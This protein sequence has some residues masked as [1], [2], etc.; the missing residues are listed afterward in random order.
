MNQHTFSP[1][2]QKHT[3]G[4][5]RITGV[6]FLIGSLW[7]LFSDRFAAALTQDPVLLTQISL[8]KGWGY[9]F[10][11]A[12][13]LYGMIQRFIRGVQAGERDLQASEMRFATIFHA[14]PIGIC[15]S[16]IETGVLVEVNE[17][18]LNLFGYTLDEVVGHS[19]IELNLWGEPA[20]RKWLIQT[21]R[22]GKKI[23]NHELLSRKKSGELKPVLVSSEIVVFNGQEYLLSLIADIFER[24][25]AEDE[26]QAQRDFALQVMN[27]MGQGLTVTDRGRKFEFANLAFAHMV[28][29]PL[30]EI[31]KH[32]TVDFVTLEDMEIQ[33]QAHQERFQGKTTSY[34]IHLKQMNGPPRPVLITGVPRM[35]KG[36][37]VGAISVIT[38][39]TERK[40]AE[41][42][43]QKSAA[44]LTSIFRAAPIG[45]GK[46]TNR[47]FEQVNDRFCQITGYAREEL[48]GQSARMIYASTEEYE[49]VGKEKF[50]QMAETGV[51]VVE[52]H[53]QRKDG[54]RIEIL[55]SSAY[56]DATHPE[57]GVTFTAQ[58]I[59]AR[60]QTEN[61]L[62]RQTA[63]LSTLYTLSEEIAASF[64]LPKI[65]AAA[66]RAATRLMPGEIFSIS[67]LCENDTIIEDVYLWDRD[68]VWPE[69]RYP[70]GTDLAGY[71][72]RHGHPLRVNQ[73]DASYDELTHAT[74]FG[75]TEE[76][77]HSLLAVPMF[78]LG[79]ACF[80]MMSVQ[81]YVPDMY[82][83]EH[84]H[85]LV[86]L[87][88]QVS[89]AI[90]NAQLYQQVQQELNERKRAEVE[91]QEN[92]A[93]LNSI[94]HS[95]MD[96]II[97][98]DA[99]YRV[100][101]FN[102]A[103]ET[104][105]RISA[106]EALGQ[107]LDKFI[108]TRFH[109][110]HHTHLKMYDKFQKTG[111]EPRHPFAGIVGVRNDGE[112]FPCEVSISQI[113]MA[114]EK[115]FT[116]ILRDMT[117]RNRAEEEIRY[118]AGL[119]ANVS[120]AIIST[121]LTYRIKSW[122]QAAEKMYGWKA[123]EVIGKTVAD[124]VP[125]IF[126]E[127]GLEQAKKQLLKDRQ[128]KGQLLQQTKEG[129]EKIFLSSA[130]LVVDASD[131]PTAIV[132]VNRDISESVKHQREVEAIVQVSTALRT[133]STRAEMIPVIL[134]QLN[135]LFD[136]QATAFTTPN[137]ATD[138]L[139]VEMARGVLAEA[140]RTRIPLGQ[141]VSGRVIATQEI[142]LDNDASTDSMIPGAEALREYRAVACVPLIAHEHAI[143]ALWIARQTAITEND[144][145]ILA[146][147]ANIAANAIHRAGLFEQTQ[148]QLE[149]LA[150]L[151][152]M[153]T[154]IAASF[155]L[156]PTLYIL[157]DQIQ[158]RLKVAAADV[159]LYNPHTL[160]LEFAAGNGFQYQ[161][162]KQIRLRLGEGCTGETALEQHI[163]AIPN[164][165]E[166]LA[167]HPSPAHHLHQTEG[168]VSYF[169]IPLISKGQ[170]KGVLELYHR[171][172]L[173]AD[174]GWLDFL[175]TLGRQVAIAMDNIEMLVGLQRSKLELELAYDATIEGW[176]RALDLRDKETEGHSQRVTEITIQLARQI[177]VSELEI[178]QMRRGALLHDI[179]KMGIPDAILLKPGQLT[180]EE[181]DVMKT[182][183]QLAYE[184]LSPIPYLHPALDIPRYHHEK[185]DGTGYPH[186]LRGEQ[187]PL[188]A[189]I[190]AL[191]DV[192][193]ALTS[194]RPYRPAWSIQKTE[195]FIQEQIGSHFDPKIAATFLDLPKN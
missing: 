57:L 129:Q 81:S 156:R 23:S 137:P 55:L 58:D 72:I 180:K 83:L 114:D 121:D 145:K 132:F 49:F 104:M 26:L 82:T 111:R 163:L 118:Q 40:Q 146:A 144:L 108:P 107:P 92:R 151:H 53:F 80:G 117:E 134:D 63:H 181:W 54:E 170:V 187:I 173:Q 27:T 75:Y 162:L 131:Q 100:V 112:E 65:Y 152:A 88:N 7:I 154:A 43:L 35:Y 68:Q 177:G 101:L 115:L 194:N 126:I 150:I 15:I 97:T 191:A 5:W 87:A 184:M 74:N 94:I 64:D 16:Q 175:E 143:G 51:G 139:V 85:F 186:G 36:E 19:S 124:L 13:L 29:M 48:I 71:V 147:V 93:K 161:E 105:F 195:Q 160:N 125:N 99:N 120:D 45:I 60:K 109:E 67:L 46:V 78:R 116:A 37:I 128:W 6:Y 9:I 155:D 77:V 123:E 2:T 192:W 96:A 12:L 4:I 33:E 61:N 182:H 167:Q 133:V 149:R 166:Y 157:L 17:A 79:G 168:F 20:Q 136:A 106:A 52:T 84:E 135:A 189:R 62:A 39:L 56:L 21:L 127:G 169:G 10:V 3:W 70:A 47:I 76:E 130:S 1:I 122:N 178:V 159:F 14:S 90:E 165:Q 22:E 31:Q 91:L 38:D 30:E 89:K 66:H 59:T 42:A 172:P 50:R 185:W 28:G 179:G 141:G 102:Q 34:E 18:F 190:F 158:A 119:L 44:E 98:I 153:D 110:R 32:R 113:E 11:T 164:F 86:T 103:A 171:T 95:A 188:A 25:R 73:W 148:Q 24:K 183:P 176:S 138:E 41:K 8:Y 140:L 69:E 142:F 193:D 174:A